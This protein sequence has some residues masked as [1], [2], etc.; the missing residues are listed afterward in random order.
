MG[1]VIRPHTICYDLGFMW[2]L[3]EKKKAAK[4]DNYVSAFKNESRGDDE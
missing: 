4:F 1:L 2:T 3:C